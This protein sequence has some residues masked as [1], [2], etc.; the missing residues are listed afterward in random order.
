MVIFVM[1]TPLSESYTPWWGYRKQ[2]VLSFWYIFY[3]WLLNCWCSTSYHEQYLCRQEMALYI[4][5]SVVLVWTVFEC[6]GYSVKGCAWT[7]N[8]LW[9]FDVCFIYL[10]GY[11]LLWFPFS[12][13][14]QHL[15]L[16]A[17]FVL[18]STYKILFKAG[19]FIVSFCIFLD[20]LNIGHLL[21]YIQNNFIQNNFILF[22]QLYS[23]TL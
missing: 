17:Y 7:F 8:Q 12:V 16:Q 20:L 10:L 14:Q 13:V 18:P 22:L 21:L 5:E 9:R 15:I 19:F 4:K 1:F 3:F 6:V 23:T 11:L 2:L